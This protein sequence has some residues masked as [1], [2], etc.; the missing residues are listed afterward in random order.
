MSDETKFYKPETLRSG[1]L[2]MLM[3]GAVIIYASTPD[4]GANP[5]DSIINGMWQGEPITEYVNFKLTCDVCEPIAEIDEDYVCYHRIGWRPVE[6]VRLARN[7]AHRSVCVRWGQDRIQR[8]NRS[9]G[10]LK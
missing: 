6:Q 5:C 10:G 1:V 8:G 9:L 7:R 2:P 3:Q 4:Y